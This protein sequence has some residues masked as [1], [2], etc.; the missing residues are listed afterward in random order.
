MTMT[1][2]E[3]IQRIMNHE[4]PDRV[5]IY[6]HYWGETLDRWWGEGMPADV[7]PEDFFEHDIAFSCESVYDDSLRFEERRLEVKGDSIIRLNAYGVTEEVWF[8]RSRTGVARVLDVTIKNLHDMDFQ[9]AMIS[10]LL[11]EGY[12]YDGIELRVACA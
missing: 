9:L 8:D 7:L 11:K 12:E 3:R 2:R 4:L 1:S 6:D 5:G 10:L